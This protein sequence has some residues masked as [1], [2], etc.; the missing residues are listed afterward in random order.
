[1]FPDDLQIYCSINNV[2]DCKL[3]QSDIDSVRNWCFENGMI[4]NVGKTTFFFPLCIKLNI[5]F[6][7][8]M[9][10]NFI[11]CFQDVKDLGVLLGFMQYISS[12]FSTADRLYVLYTTPVQPKLE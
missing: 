6:K 1:L 8:R 3:L 2:H 12:S 10:N 7:Y 4:P 11:L 5:N 9:C